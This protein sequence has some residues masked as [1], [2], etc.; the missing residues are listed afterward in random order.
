MEDVEMDTPR[1]RFRSRGKALAGV[2]TLAVL[3]TLLPNRLATHVSAVSGEAV[4]HG[5]LTFDGR[6]RTYRLYA[7][8]S[9]PDGPVPLF[10]GL[11]GGSGWGD[12]FA[13]T[14]HVESLAASNGFIVVH[15]DGVTIPGQRGGVWNG[16]MCCAIAARENV[17][18]VGFVNALIDEL[19]LDYD[20]DAQRVFAFGHSNGGIMSYRLACELADRIVGIGVVAGTL[21]VDTCDPTQPVS[22][23][24]VHGTADRNLPITGG[25]GPDSRAGVDF[26]PPREGFATIA[27]RDGCPAAEEA[28]VGD[29][30]TAMR[31]PCDAAAAAAFVTIESA[32]HPW[33]GGTAVVPPASG[34]VYQDYDATVEIVEFLLSHP[35]P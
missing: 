17:D 18:D 25:V 7:P 12:Q 21:G 29:V 2:A 13:R 14:N 30:T 4:T 32:A 10:I 31:A 8:S 3:C 22:L 33:P 11:H 23:I 34:A 20:I 28:T 1:P 15:P 6:E 19:A 5:A 16:G 27:E 26:P 35:R 24:H 9:L